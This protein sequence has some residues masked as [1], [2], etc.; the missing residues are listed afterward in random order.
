MAVS[1]EP[2][3]SRASLCRLE[4]AHLRTVVL[5]PSMPF[6]LIVCQPCGTFPA[7]LPVLLLPNPCLHV[8]ASTTP[9]TCPATPAAILRP[10]LRLPATHT[11]LLARACSW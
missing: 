8:V 10:A 11:S 6:N 3:L 9:N 1:C 5:H 4:D 2:S 7:P